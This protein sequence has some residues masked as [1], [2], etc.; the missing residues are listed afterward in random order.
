[1]TGPIPLRAAEAFRAAFR[2]APSTA[3][4]LSLG[5][6]IGL[7]GW[8]TPEM[9]GFRLPENDELVLALHLG[10][11]R[12]V[13]AVH[14]G[15]GLSEACSRPGLV[16]LLPPG[17]AACFRTE[18]SV[19][20][21][22][23]HLARPREWNDGLSALCRPG[24][25]HFAVRDP[26]LSASLEAL[27]RAARTAPVAPADYT[28]KLTDA[29]L[30]HLAYW[31][32]EEIPARDDQARLGARSLREVLDHLDTHL[33]SAPDLDQMARYAGLGRAAFTRG[34]RRLTGCSAHRYLLQR[35]IQRACVLLQRTDHDLAWIAQESGFSSQSHFTA[36][37][38]A[39]IG[40][41]PHRYRLK[42]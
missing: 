7:Y 26:F 6:G 10:G 32:A 30:S 23:L 38:R 12:R 9:E 19:R 37:F 1:M 13:R 25:A 39:L 17:Q 3:L 5:P 11:S 31:H 16:T 24:A 42:Q 15:G 18:G 8:D 41:T 34:F 21:A 36:Q 2:V 27:M 22:T 29:L 20:V 40:E 28:R 14:E 33:A 4:E 35:R